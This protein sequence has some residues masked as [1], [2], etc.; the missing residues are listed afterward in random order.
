MFSRKLNLKI[1]ANLEKLGHL[2]SK[3]FDFLIGIDPGL[4][5]A[6][7]VLE[8][9]RRLIAIHDLPIEGNGKG[10]AK[11]KNQI[12]APE[13]ANILQLYPNA[14]ACLEMVASRPGQG[15]ASVFSLGD[16]FGCIRGTLGSLRIPFILVSP[17]SW[18]TACGIAKGADKDYSRTLA[19][20]LYPSA[21]IGLKKHHNRAE[22]LLL[23]RHILKSAH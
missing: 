21:E 17:N 3:T 12:S 8:R 9:G 1:N 10:K 22:A 14:I 15:V 7:A 18:K 23:A 11:V 19:L 16:S 4:T 6:V 20:Q 13:L 2:T 5:G